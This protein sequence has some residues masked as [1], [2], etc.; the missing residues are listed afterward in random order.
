MKLCFGLLLAATGIYAQNVIS[1]RSG[2]IHRID[3]P[4]VTLEGKQIKPKVGE[5]PQMKAGETLSTERAKVEILLTPGVFFRLGEDSSFKLVSDHLSDTRVEMLKGSAIMEVD[6]IQKGNSVMLLYKDAKIT[7]SKHGLY[8][9]DADKNL[10]KVSDGEAQV[11]RGDDTT[12]VKAGHQLEFGAVFLATKF[13]KKSGDSLDLWSQE[14]SE[15]IARANLNS[16]NSMRRGGSSSYNSYT[17]GS[18]V[19][20]PYFDIISYLPASGYGY[21]PYGWLIYSPRTVVYSYY[22]NPNPA[23]SWQ[24][25][26][27][28]GDV[29]GANAQGNPGLTSSNSQVGA[30]SAPAA[31]AP[32][33]ASSVGGM[34]RAPVS[35]GGGRGR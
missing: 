30:I 20:N 7:P 23:A 13:N 3:G 21:S 27:A 8:R 22:G 17:A 35:G 15:R 19:L 34:S 1:A 16:A 24:A 31:M 4:S 10:L 32:S 26:N 33:G 25:S 2:L 28:N 18:W 9:L 6:D 29:R 14:E 12:V 5:F 11:V